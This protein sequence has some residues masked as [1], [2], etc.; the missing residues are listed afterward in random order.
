MPS[1][2]ASTSPS[3]DYIDWKSRNTV[4]QSLD[5]YA[6]YG[7]M[8]RTPDG[9][10]LPTA[11]ASPPASSALSALRPPSAAIS[12]P[13]TA[14]SPP[15]KVALISYAAWQRRFAGRTVVLGQTVVLDGKPTIIIGV[16]PRDFHFAPAEPADFWSNERADGGCE[17]ARACHKLLGLAR[18]KP[19]VYLRFSPRQRRNISFALAQAVSRRDHGRSAFMMPLNQVILGNI[20]PILLVLLA[21][22]ALLLLIAAVN[23]SSLLL[24]RSERRR[25][26]MAVR[27]ALGASRTRLIRQFVTEGAVL[28][29]SAAVL[30]VCLAGVLIRLRPGFLP[31]DVLASMP[32]LRQV[33]L[34]VRVLAFAASFVALAAGF[35]FSLLPALRISLADLRARPLAGW[36]RRFPAPSGVASVPISSSSSSPWPSCFWSALASWARA[37]TTSCTSIPDWSPITS[38]H[39]MSRPPPRLQQ[40][41][42]RNQSRPPAPRPSPGSSRRPVRRPYQ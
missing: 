2:R 4:F 24:V 38:L 18:L 6:A 23:V 3:F 19:G 37:S 17:K 27:G 1:A 20:R 12:V 5:A 26:E 7:F 14:S 35:L 8:L 32:Y 36:T 42:R 40:S 15:R 10:K 33:G 13:P 30:G 11:P 39:S 41:P 34:N 21:G 22:A 16:L 28:A 9:P 25:R 31:K 29:A